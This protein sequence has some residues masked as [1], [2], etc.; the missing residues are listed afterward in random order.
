MSEK[1]IPE[2][3]INK[4]GYCIRADLIK[5]AKDYLETS[6]A[7]KIG[8]FSAKQEL[9]KDGK[10]KIEVTYP[11]VPTV[12]HIVAAAEKFYQFVNKNSK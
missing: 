1:N 2:V 7:Y 11:T 4:N 3:T 12:D 9:S 5:Y 8:E 10:L 6:Y